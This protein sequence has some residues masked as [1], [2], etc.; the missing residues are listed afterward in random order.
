MLPAGVGACLW[1]TATDFNASA[2]EETG[3]DQDYAIAGDGFF[4]VADLRTGE[5]SLTRNGAFV[6][7]SLQRP[8]GET[9]ENGETLL[10]ENGQP[11]METIGY[12][13]DNQGRFVLSKTGGMI[14]VD[15]VHEE[16]PVGVFDYINYNGMQHIEG[17][18]FQ[19]IDK[20]GGIRASDTPLMRKHIEMSNADLADE[21][22][23]VIE[24]Q[25]AYGRALK[26]VQA[27]DEIETTINGLRG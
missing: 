18:R 3:R 23:K 20:N 27:S 26:M 15:D 9:D 4:A 7:S 14:E 13:S 5:I 17:S 21:M 16:Q 22:T 24:T 1:T 2:I 19:A 10:D 6:I 12:L 25:R 8:S 11:M